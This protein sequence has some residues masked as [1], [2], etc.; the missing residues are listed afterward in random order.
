[1]TESVMVVFDNTKSGQSLFISVNRA[2][3]PWL[4]LNSKNPVWQYNFDNTCQIEVA[5]GSNYIF[6]FIEYSSGVGAR[7]FVS[8]Q[9]ITGAPNLTTAQFVFDKI[10]MGWNAIWNQTSVD[11][12]GIPMQI[13]VNDS[14]PYGFKDTASRDVVLQ[15]LMNVTAPYNTFVY[16]VGAN[17]PQSIYRMFSPGQASSMGA[18]PWGYQLNNCLSQA[19]NLGLAALNGYQG[20]FNYGGFVMTNFKQLSSTSISLSVNGETITLTN[21]TTDGAL[22]CT[23]ASSPNDAAG[24]KAAGLIGAVIN[25]GVLYNPALWGQNVPPNSGYPINYY[26]QAANNAN[27]FNYYAQFLHSMSLD[28]LCYAMPYD[29]F[30]EQDA[31]M[32]VSAG[33]KVRITPLSLLYA[34]STK[35]LMART[36]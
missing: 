22:A 14:P 31:A 28:G 33:A 7:L 1:M 20:P 16:P 30:F 2:D 19:I 25:R 27:Q 18:P 3:G 17:S 11:F 12:L 32:T 26:V 35:E 34:M 36:T 4:T 29:D 21:V 23:I 5:S 24:Q 6:P 10:E 8:Q 13:Q 15:G 9:A